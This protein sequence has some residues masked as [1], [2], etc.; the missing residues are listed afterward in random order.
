MNPLFSLKCSATYEGFLLGIDKSRTRLAVPLKFGFY[1][2]QFKVP[3]HFRRA[4][5]EL[6][7]E[8]MR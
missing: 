4:L 8:R 3:F 1:G 6:I 5:L 7:S 2:V